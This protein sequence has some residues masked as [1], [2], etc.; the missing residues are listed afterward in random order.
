MS[1]FIGSIHYW[2]YDKIRLVTQREEH[3]YQKAFE[4]W[5]NSERDQGTGLAD[6]WGAAA[7]C[8]PWRT[9]RP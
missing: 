2:L 6:I 9:P 3:I 4:M 5:H 8:R 1:T 7:G